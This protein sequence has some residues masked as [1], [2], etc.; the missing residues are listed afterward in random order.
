MFSSRKAQPCAK[1]SHYVPGFRRNE[2]KWHF[3][4]FYETVKL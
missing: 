3:Q 1:T 4:T 2:G